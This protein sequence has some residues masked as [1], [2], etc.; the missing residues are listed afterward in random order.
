MGR[1]EIDA[2]IRILEAER[3]KGTAGHAIGTWSITYE[4]A[5]NAFV[6]NTCEF[7][8]YCEERP[9]V[10]SVSGDVIDPGGPLFS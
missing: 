10:I 1:E 9:A 7:D 4:K 6:F 5:R 3:A 2:L 8:G